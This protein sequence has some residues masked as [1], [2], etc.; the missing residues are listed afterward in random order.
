MPQV[1]I[2]DG[3]ISFARSRFNKQ[4]L[5]EMRLLRI[6]FFALAIVSSKQILAQCINT[7]PHT[8]TFESAASWISGGVN[9]DWAWGA[10]S[11]GIIT[12]AG[13]GSKCWITGGLN[14]SS[15]NGNQK[16]YIESPC[17]DLSSLTSP[18][19]SFK[20]FWETEYVYDGTSLFYSLNNGASWIAVGSFNEPPSC[21]TQ[22]WYNHGSIN[23]LN[24]AGSGNGWSGNSKSTSGSCQGGNGS[25]T[26]I[27]AK[28][29]L[30]GLA[31]QS[32]VKFR[33]NF[34]SGSTCNAFD[35][36]AMDDFTIGDA[37]NNS[38]SFT[39][40]CSNFSVSTP[41]CTQ[42]MSY[43]WNFGDATSTSNTSTL[44][45]P[46]HIYHTPGIYTVSLTSTGGACGAVATSTQQ[47]SVVGATVSSVSNVMCYGGS[48][49]SAGIT[50][51]NG[52]A[53][54]TYTWLPVGGNSATANSLS[55][56]NYTV[57]IADSKNCVNSQTVS[58]TQPNIS[59][60]L[61]TQTVTTCFGDNAL[62][63]VNVSGITDPVSYLWSPGSY[64]SNSVYVS[65]QSNTVYSVNVVVSGNCPISEQKLYTVIVVP[66]PV[67]LSI[68]TTAKGCEPLCID[69]IDKSTSQ[70]TI[71]KNYW[72]FSN[73]TNTISTDPKI[74][75]KNAGIYT[76][77]HSVTNNYGCT[78]TA[79]DFIAITVHPQPISKFETD[80]KEVT[81]L[82][83]LVKFKDLSIGDPEKWEWNFGG[84]AN[85]TLK[86]PNYNF[87]TIGQYPVLLTVTNKFGCE[88][89]SIQHI[90]VLPEFTFFAPNSFTPNDDG[91]NDI[92][93]PAGMGWNIDAYN[94]MIFNRWGQK[95]FHTNDHTQGWNGKIKESDTS[96]ET[97]S[98]IYKAQVYDNYKKLHEYTG[99]V[100]VIK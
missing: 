72:S 83:P 14:S 82:D 91:L 39:Y 13:S 28:H 56:G 93:L 81:E 33:F 1:N 2:L 31:G 46:T 32:N 38:T 79:N 15:Y 37:G 78:S 50:A 85:S 23:Y 92:F 76:G 45:N 88:N 7:F 25:L 41:T 43:A 19:V 48:S 61:S 64:T 59:T 20:V 34:G 27:T 24:W 75:F 89:T 95:I 53:P 70:G 65:P 84:E 71:T 73:G 100:F 21:T 42:G 60:G 9:S 40:T 47:I 22:N 97:G 74:C 36:F 80:K 62:L 58:I 26:W 86:D 18:Y 63:Q 16:S 54:Y 49:G 6:I 90:R 30:S 8:E 69:F 77:K 66:K 35:G 99:T 11:K 10:P 52:Q 5:I 96:V 17:Y 57:L 29:C 51:L 44:S 3:K 87:N 67:V 4:L 68:N 94:L 55:A 12:A 98:Y